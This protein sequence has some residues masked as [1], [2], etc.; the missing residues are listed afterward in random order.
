L[1]RDRGRKPPYLGASLRINK[2]AARAQQ[3]IDILVEE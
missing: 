1:G 2:K 3:V